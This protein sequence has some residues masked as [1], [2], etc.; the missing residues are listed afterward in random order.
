MRRTLLCLF[1]LSL[2]VMPL[3]G[4]DA[5]R[6]FEIADLYRVAGVGV[7]EISPDGSRVAFPVTRYDLPAGERWSEIWVMAPDGSGLRQMTFGRHGN[8]TPLFSPD[9]RTLLFT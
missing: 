7:P 2:S 3:E 9:G 6:A 5:K 4:A 8:D 1:S